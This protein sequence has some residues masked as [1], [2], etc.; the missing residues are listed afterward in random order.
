[1][2]KKRGK[3]LTKARK[4]FVGRLVDIKEMPPSWTNLCPFD[5]FMVTEVV[6]CRD[7]EDD[8]MVCVCGMVENAGSCI[9]GFFPID[10]VRLK[11]KA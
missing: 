10:Q 4:K 3:K 9:A 1:M 7:S 6:A 8:L 11:E 5:R 2:S